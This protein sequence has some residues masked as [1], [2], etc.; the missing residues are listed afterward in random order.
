[1]SE[2]RNHHYVPQFYLRAFATDD[3]KKKIDNALNQETKDALRGFQATHNLEPT[4]EADQATLDK[5]RNLHDG[6]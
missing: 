4:G 1:M 3:G 2:P 6:I 5:L